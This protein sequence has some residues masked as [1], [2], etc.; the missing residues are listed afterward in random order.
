[1]INKS[2]GVANRNRSLSFWLLSIYIPIIFIFGG[3][4]RDDVQSV[5][6]LHP[7]SVAMT[8]IA[9]ILI[10]RATV[11]ENKIIITISTTLVI[12][13]AAYLVPLPH[14]HWSGFAGH[15]LIEEVERATVIGNVWRPLAINPIGGIS[16][17]FSI[18]V[19][20]S[21]LLL[22]LQTKKEERLDILMILI[23][24][25]MLSALIG[26]FQTIGDANGALY[27][28]RLTNNGSAVGL[29]ANRNHQAILLSIM[30]PMI[31]VF[32]VANNQ[33]RFQRYRSTIALSLGTFLV[34]M[35]F[36]TGSRAG[37]VAGI[38]AIIFAM[39]LYWRSAHRDSLQLPKKAHKLQI[40]MISGAAFALGIVTIIASRAI[41]LER[42]LMTG[43]GLEDRF[44]TWP[45]IIEMAWHYF[46]V[47]VGPNGFSVGYAAS[48]NPY[49]LDSTYLN[50][51]HNDWI[52]LFVTFGLLPTVLAVIATIAVA[53]KF[54]EM[55]QGKYGRRDTQFL[56]LGLV[57]VMI[58]S[59]GSVVDYPIRTPTIAAVTIL[60]LS[61][62]FGAKSNRHLKQAKAQKTVEVDC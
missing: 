44:S 1:M 11:T 25:G 46:P 59:L 60:A 61:W 14:A 17:L 5:V 23:F 6:V 51:A 33:P 12:V 22:A 54:F 13:V 10:K 30:F 7:L 39:I 32:A 50:R 42:L 62:V 3:S 28:Y 37:L 47:G 56:Q 20:V 53:L 4:S 2:T 48:E 41:A 40:I 19:P 29:F 52:E 34:P 24:L 27:F 58:V 26:L 16:T 43:A 38:L 45:S 49:L 35:I 15:Q 21:V 55:L 57:V 8:A 31:A 36:V 9:L 18:M